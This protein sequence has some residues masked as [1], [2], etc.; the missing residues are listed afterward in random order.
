MAGLRERKRTETRQRISAGATRLFEQNGFENVKLVEIAAAADVSVNTVLNYFRAKEDMFFDAEPASC[1]ELVT[2]L[3]VRGPA[4][5]ATALRP[6]LVDS[7]IL[8]GSLPWA[9]V[10]DSWWNALRERAVCERQ[11]PALTARRASIL[12]SWMVPLAEVTGSAAG[13]AM[14]TGILAL[15]QTVIQDGLIGGQGPSTVGPRV[16]TIMS[17]A[18]DALERAFP[19]EQLSPVTPVPLQEARQ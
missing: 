19:A 12:L 7:P 10:E 15:R 9:S 13:A 16:R 5:S 4:S 2:A 14:V 17:N 8:A 1:D 6:L 18:L 11:S 3:S